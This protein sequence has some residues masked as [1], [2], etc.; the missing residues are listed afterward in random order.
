MRAGGFALAMLAEIHPTAIRGMGQGFVYSFGRGLSALAPY[1]VGAL[2]DRR[3][4]GTALGLNA[5]FF[6]AAAAL[7]FLPPETRAMELEKV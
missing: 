5:G 1:A 3:G 2:A 7:V 6:L 4:L